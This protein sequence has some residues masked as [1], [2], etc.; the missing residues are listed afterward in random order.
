MILGK[1]FV[2]VQARPSG[3]R[4]SRHFGGVRARKDR[5]EELLKTLVAMGQAREITPDQFLAG[6][7]SPPVQ[8]RKIQ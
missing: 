7:G 3:A 1:R 8:P 5:V 6:V 4:C 2:M